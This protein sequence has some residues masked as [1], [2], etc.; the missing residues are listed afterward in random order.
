MLRAR[1]IA[2]AES[3]R[4]NIIGI[5]GIVLILIF[6]MVY[7]EPINHFMRW[8]IHSVIQAVKDAFGTS[9]DGGAKDAGQ[10]R[11]KHGPGSTT[12]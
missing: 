6:Y 1:S 8:S 7:P 5:V 12:P 10:I 11:T 2:R 3:G 4:M 9:D